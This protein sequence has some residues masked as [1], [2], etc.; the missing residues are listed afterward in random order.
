MPRALAARLALR[1]AQ[2]CV[3]VG[4]RPA[5]TLRPRF[6][7]LRTY[8]TAQSAPEAAVRHRLPV[9]VITGFLGSG[10]TTLLNH[11][12]KQPHGKRLAIIENEYGEVGVDDVLVQRP[13]EGE[14]TQSEELFELNNGC[15]CCTVRGDLVRILGKLA[16]RRDRLDGVVIETTGL[17][18]PVPVIQTFLLDEAVEEDFELDGVVTVVDA[19][20]INRRLDSQPETDGAKELGT[21]EALAQIAFADRVIL[22]KADLVSAEQLSEVQSRLTDINGAA[23]LVTTE[24]GQVSP[25]LLLDIGGL[26]PLKLAE[27][28]GVGGG[29]HG[30]SH[31]SHGSGHGHGHGHSHGKHHHHHR[32][33]VSSV[34]IRWVGDVNVAALDCWLQEIANTDGIELFRYKGVI[35]V[36]NAPEKFYFQGVHSLRQGPEPLRG[37]KWGDEERENRL[38]FIG[39]GLD[40]E[41]VRAG[42]EICKAPDQ[43]RFAIGDAVRCF[44]VKDQ[45]RA[46]VAGVVREHWH[47]GFPYVVELENGQG[48]IYAPVDHD[49]VISKAD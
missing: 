43:L 34:G 10:K 48:F 25:D 22:N 2:R 37:V 40:E 6:Q 31:H 29:G 7:H 15:I 11:L 28:R 16:E 12:L 44:V 30:H 26:N 18:N 42:F 35:A 47:R 49:G 36:R 46:Q 45:V 13:D 3:R 9:T 38:V 5:P 20:H 1:A 41:K 24:H 23:E 8:C 21:N 14:G 39:T 19:A 17:A 32:D 27:A 4:W 33:A